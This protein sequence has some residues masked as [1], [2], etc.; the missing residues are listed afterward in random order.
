M[1]WQ[2]VRGVKARSCSAPLQEDI[3]GHAIGGMKA[4]NPYTAAVLA[5]I[6]DVRAAFPGVEIT[7]QD[8]HPEVDLNID[9]PRQVGR[10]FD[11]NLNL[12]DDELHLSVG[13]FWRSEHP[14]DRPDVLQ[15]FREAVVGLLSG[16]HRIVNHYRGRRLVAGDLERLDAGEWKTVAE[17]YRRLWFG[18][19][20]TE[21]LSTST[22]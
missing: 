8:D 19:K 2:P 11:M 9:I 5:L 14:C 10:P 7:V 13:G 4:L 17:G 1:M 16:S 22:S 18:R 21:I 15:W 6:G 3:V 12:Q 20:R